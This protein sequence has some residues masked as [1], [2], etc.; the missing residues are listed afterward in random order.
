VVH[1]VCHYQTEIE[2]YMYIARA[3]FFYIS[4]N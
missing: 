4:H 2:I 1:K 3:I